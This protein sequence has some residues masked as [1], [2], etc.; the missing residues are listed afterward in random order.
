[1]QVAEAAF[2]IVNRESELHAAENLF[3]VEQ[4]FAHVWG[5][6]ITKYTS[7]QNTGWEAAE[8]LR[9]TQTSTQT[10]LRE[11]VFLFFANATKC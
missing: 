4:T 9:E 3:V 11:E 1:M 2:R 8:G 5:K 10:H 6:K 7:K